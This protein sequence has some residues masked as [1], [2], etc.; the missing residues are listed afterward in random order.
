MSNPIY[1]YVDF[2]FPVSGNYVRDM[3]AKNIVPLVEAEFRNFDIDI[4]YAAGYAYIVGASVYSTYV[5]SGRTLLYTYRVNVPQI[6][7]ITTEAYPY[8][9]DEFENPSDNL[10]RRVNDI[11]PEA[12][13]LLLRDLEIH[14]FNTIGFESAVMPP[15]QNINELVVVTEAYREFLAESRAESDRRIAA[16]I[17][18]GQPQRTVFEIDTSI[19]VQ[20]SDELGLNNRPR[21]K[22]RPRN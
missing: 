2:L 3:I 11:I 12:D 20:F 19:E 15:F 8:L 6:I 4:E 21:K 10:L 17:E 22:K 13:L 9:E 7:R 16:L 14:I 18:L 5:Q 1:D